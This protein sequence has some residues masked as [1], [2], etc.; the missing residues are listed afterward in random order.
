MINIDRYS[1]SARQLIAML[2]GLIS[3]L[4]YSVL[5]ITEISVIIVHTDARHKC[6]P[7]VWHAVVTCGVIRICSAAVMVFRTAISDGRSKNGLC[8]LF[9]LCVLPWVIICYFTISKFC[10]DSI[11]YKHEELW[12]MLS[13][14]LVVLSAVL[15]IFI[16]VALFMYCWNLFEP[17]NVTFTSLFRETPVYAE[18]PNPD[19]MAERQSHAIAMNMALSQSIAEAVEAVI[20]EGEQNPKKYVEGEV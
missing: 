3:A 18:P 1:P 20:R 7:G 14:E 15:G 8:H 17:S 12:I 11:R 5:G 6:G 9:Q 10:E 2:P 4:L 13:V 16:F 19:L